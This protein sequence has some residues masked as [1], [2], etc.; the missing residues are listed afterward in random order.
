MKAIKKAGEE[1]GDQIV[2]DIYG[3]ITEV[4]P[5]PPDRIVGQSAT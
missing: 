1:K 2:K 5:E 4:R 3:I